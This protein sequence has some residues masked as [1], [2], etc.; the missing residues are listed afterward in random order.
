MSTNSD[1]H[2]RTLSTE[3][4]C[5][6]DHD[7]LPIVCPIELGLVGVGEYRYYVL[8]LF[9]QSI[10]RKTNQTQAERVRVRAEISHY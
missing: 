2:S 9:S 4:T 1:E 6:G 8:Q 3:K 7:F 5:S 10:K